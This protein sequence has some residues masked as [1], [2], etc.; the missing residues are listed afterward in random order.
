[1][2]AL[3]AAVFAVSAA[4]PISAQA[5]REVEFQ[6]NYRPAAFDALAREIDNVSLVV[7]EWFFVD[8][9]GT[10][11]GE[12]ESRLLDLARKHNVP[13]M[14]QVKNYDRKTG[15]FSAAWA[16][17][18]VSEKAS[19][20]RAI[21]KFLELCKTHR[22]YGI[23]VELEGVH[24]SDRD[25]MSQFIREAAAALHK[26]GYKLSVSAIHREEDA[27]GPNSYTQWMYEYWRGAYDLKALGQAADFVRGVV[28]A[29]H[30]RRTPPG[31]SQNFP[32]LERVMSHFIASIPPEKI[33][34][35]LGMGAQRVAFEEG[36]SSHGGA[37][38]KVPLLGDWSAKLTDWMFKD[39]IPTIM[40]K[41]GVKPMMRV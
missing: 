41:V 2:R 17:G 25:S 39:Y 37:F 20:E 29:Q 24:I 40:M 10:L 31:P 21:A 9:T 12:A 16:H 7:P 19:R 5:P 38:S 34:I 18:L 6:F 28:Y 22:L 23:Q 36:L 33:V 30:T 3:L 13:V 4:L 8:S 11:T 15:L 1:M 26:E 32:W 35:G 14:P 27:P